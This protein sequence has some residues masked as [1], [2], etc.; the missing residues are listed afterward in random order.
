M[1]RERRF[2]VAIAMIGF[3]CLVGPMWIDQFPS[4]YVE[5]KIPMK[6]L[7]T[8][9]T[10]PGV[11]TSLQATD[12]NMNI[13]LTWDAP[14]DNGESPVTNYSIY[15]GLDSC[16]E[17]YFTTVGN[18]T[19]WVDTNV[20]LGATYFYN[21]SAI[22]ALGEGALSDEVFAS[23]YLIVYPPDAPTSLVAIA[24]NQN[25]TLTWDAP[26]ENGGVPITNYA[27]Y[28]GNSSGTEGPVPVVIVD[29]VRTWM[30][31]DVVAGQSYYYMVAAINFMTG[32]L[33]NEAYATP[34]IEDSVPGAPTSLL[35]TPGDQSITIT[36]NAPLTNG[37]SPITGYTIYQGYISGGEWYLTTLGNITTWTNTGLMNGDTYY[38]RVAAINAI[39]EGA[40]SNEAC[41]V[42]TF[43]TTVPG[44]PREFSANVYYNFVNLN[45]M[46]PVN[47]GGSPIEEYWIYRGTVSGAETY[48]DHC[49][50]GT[51]FLAYSDYNVTAG[52]TYYYFVTAVNSYGEGPA[53][54][55]ASVYVPVTVPGTP[56][57]LV[58]IAGNGQVE[59]SW[60][61]PVNDGGMAITGYQIQVI[62]PDGWD[63]VDISNVTTYIITGLINGQEYY[64]SVAAVNFIGT[65]L[66][67]SE[68][69]C[70]P[71]FSLQFDAGMMASVV[72]IS[73]A[74]AVV[75]I[76]VSTL[77]IKRK[78]ANEKIA[79]SSRNAF[80]RK[81]T[82][83]SQQ[84]I[85][86]KAIADKVMRK[87]FIIFGGDPEQVTIFRDYIMDMYH[88]SFSR[89]SICSA[90]DGL[91]TKG[92]VN[93]V[94]VMEEFIDEYKRS[95]RPDLKETAATVTA[96]LVAARVTSYVEASQS[97]PDE[98][99]TG[100]RQ[101]LFCANCRCELLS[102]GEGA[103]THEKQIPMECPRCKNVFCIKC[104][105][106]TATV[107]GLTPGVMCPVCLTQWK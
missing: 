89:D 16:A 33:S 96:S 99:Q 15:R 97:H 14:L 26:L 50:T 62:T 107:H 45:W 68:V 19:T 11:P 69:A 1:L 63:Y 52:M 66:Y 40:L 79:I 85:S 42:P 105:V 88:S 81:S 23:P 93:A 49:S 83:E 61:P 7:D 94:I 44:G 87:A 20:V 71:L 59:L 72:L 47:P 29:D 53:S 22:N 10:V 8:S 54:E 13:T 74:G 103:T 5:I 3:A 84:R 31:V 80:E 37:G 77:V 64:F 39:G 12:G 38:Y 6:D 25:I 18:V 28:R 55:L 76:T 70:T 34:Y 106:H 43:S 101:D 86:F 78:R 32:A 21:V 82:L 30:D 73:I 56:T 57:S 67:S 102:Q 48:Y 9:A 24:G 98:E 95:P 51:G 75:A 65:G 4:L 58:V 100:D 92:N 2:L 60:Q 17:T 90:L 27:I 46:D 104:V 35:A 91:E 36:W 41:A